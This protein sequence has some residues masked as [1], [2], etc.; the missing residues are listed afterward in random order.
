VNTYLVS[1]FRDDER[2][3]IGIPMIQHFVCEADDESHAIE[4]LKDAEP[5]GNVLCV[6]LCIAVSRVV[7]G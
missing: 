1:Y 2:D 3:A 4:Q 7:T 5:D 6:Y